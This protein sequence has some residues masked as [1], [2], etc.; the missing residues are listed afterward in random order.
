MNENKKKYICREVK[1]MVLKNQQYKCANSIKDYNCL[2]WMINNGNFDE[3]GYQFD[4]INEFCLSSDNTVNNIQALCPNCHAVKTKRFMQN[5]KIFSTFE[6]ENGRGVMEVDNRSP[7][8]KSP[9]YISDDSDAMDVDYYNDCYI[10][11]NKKNRNK[12]F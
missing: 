9:T 11:T 8:N 3:S 2:L 7:N 12:K 1:D 10:P 5:K 6:L 4:H